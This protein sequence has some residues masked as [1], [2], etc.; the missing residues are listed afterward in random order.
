MSRIAVFVTDNARIA[1]AVAAVVILAGSLLAGW[2]TRDVREAQRL[3]ALKLDSERR[4]IELMSLTLNGNLMG[5]ISLIGL[6][7]EDVRHDAAGSGELNAP[8]LAARLEAIGRAYGA[9]GVF[10]VGGDGFVKSSWDVSGKS[11]T[12]TDIRFRPYYR[13]AMQGR[14]NVYAAISMARGDRALYFTA[15]V[16]P[17]AARSGDPVGAVV[18]RAGLAAVDALLRTDTGD[19]LLLAPQG[20]V[21]AGSRPDWIGV[22][23][24]EPTPARLEAIRAL[25]QFGARFDSGEPRTLP[26][27]VEDGLH[28]VDGRRWAVTRTRVRWNDPSGDWTLVMLEDLERTVPPADAAMAVLEAGALL[29]L[30]GLLSLAL[31]RGHHRQVVATLRIEDYARAQEVSATRR[32][33]IAEA[34]RR[35]Q[36]AKSASD[37]AGRFFAEAHAM[38]GALEGAVYVFPNAGAAAM[39]LVGSYAAPPGLAATLAPGEGLLGQCALDGEGRVL[40]IAGDESHLIRSGLGNSVPAAVMMAPLVRDRSTLGVVEIALLEPPG[41]ALHELFGE[42]TALLAL[43]LEI[44]RRHVPAIEVPP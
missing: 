29:L 44:L 32:T 33:K 25:K 15:P 8:H 40:V 19:S 30:I 18:A 35:F 42:M 43:N 38:L 14:Q 39:D 6:L 36:Q 2:V 9:D 17:A 24:G 23:A 41:E 20:V 27:P 21:F 22:L 26:V 3:S 16:F 31:L 1:W 7:D 4:G 11:S 12:G 13:M 28:A 37:L 34:A 10:V 5:A